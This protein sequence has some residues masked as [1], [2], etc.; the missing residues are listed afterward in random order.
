MEVP[1]VRYS[2]EHAASCA[3]AYCS[4][5]GAAHIPQRN[6]CSQPVS[7]ERRHIPLLLRENYVVAEKSDGVRYALFLYKEGGRH[8]SFLV[9]RKLTLFQIPVAACSRAFEGSVFD[10]ELVWIQGAQGAWL[11]LFLVFDVVAVN[12]LMD[13][14]RQN[15][16]RRLQLIRETFD[17]RGERATSPT[18]ASRLA[19]QGKIICGGN[20]YGLSFRPKP[21]FPMDQLDTLLRQIPSLQYATDGFV[22][23][24]V[25]DPVCTGTGERIFK[26]KTRH[27]VDLEVRGGQLLVGQGGGAETAA[28]RVPLNAVG[29]PLRASARLAAVVA[30]E[31]ADTAIVEC[32]LL[33]AGEHIEID[34]V[35]Q[36]QDKAHPNT[37]RTLLSTVINLREDIQ[38]EELCG[39]AR[40]AGR[41]SAQDSDG[42]VPKPVCF[43]AAA[44]GA[45]ELANVAVADV[46]HAHDLLLA[47]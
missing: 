2:G 42:S 33:Q 39:L 26:L 35:R 22:F 11:Q 34:L 5:W 23:T 29:A 45:A 47:R 30:A 15:L 24:P 31:R 32:S 27:T 7:L 44:Q 1:G 3:R 4:F 46:L 41:Q 13:I 25:D 12:G 38:I 19:K 17:L 14:Q 18:Y 6:P 40:Y 21:C 36:R 43:E 37:V 10:G 20:A 9:D 8:F 16:H 28:Q